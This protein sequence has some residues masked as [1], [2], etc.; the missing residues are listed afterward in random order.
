MFFVQ[1]FCNIFYFRFLKK[2]YNNFFEHIYLN[3]KDKYFISFINVLRK[4]NEFLVYGKI[5]KFKKGVVA[6]KI[7]CVKAIKFF[8]FFK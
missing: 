4:Y 1:F 8:K 6:F 5:N 7:Y 2:A 3:Y